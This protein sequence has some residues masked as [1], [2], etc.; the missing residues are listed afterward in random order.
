MRYYYSTNPEEVVGPIEED[1]V[2]LLAKNGAILDETFVIK[3]GEAEWQTYVT[4]F[5]AGLIPPP[6]PSSTLATSSPSVAYSGFWRRTAAFAIDYILLAFLSGFIIVALQSVPVS[7][8]ERHSSSNMADMAR[9]L[10]FLAAGVYFTMMESSRYQGTLGK[11]AFG[12]RV[13]DEKGGRISGGRA[14]GRFFAKI[15]SAL[16]L[17]IGYIMVAFTPKKQGLHDIISNCLVIKKT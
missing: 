3:E 1:I 10:S 5:P 9:S 17:G 15:I 14:T 4:Y 12:L 7:P 2:R 13:T 16:I 11:I 6:T 8:Y